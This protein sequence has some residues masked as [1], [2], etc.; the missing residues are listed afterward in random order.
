MGFDCT[1]HL[2]DEQ[3]IWN[4]FVPRLLGQS[5]KKT[6]LDR[7]HDNAA[8]LW[9]TARKALE[10][11]VNDEGEEIG[12][13]SVASLVCQLAC[14]YSACFLPHHYERGLAFSLWP[15]DLLEVELP[16]RFAHSPEPLF[17]EVVQ[18]YPRLKGKFPRWFT[19]NY[20]TGVYIPAEKVSAV[21][22]WLEEQLQTLSK[23]DRRTYRGLLAM[24]RAAEEKKLA[25]W[26]ATDLAIPVVGQVPG[27]PALFT[28]NYLRNTPGGVAPAEKFELP[29][30]ADWCCAVGETHVLSDSHPEATLVLDVSRWPPRCHTRRREFSWTGD[31]DGKGCWLLVSRIGAR[32]EVST[33]R[34]RVYTDLRK[35]PVR[36]VQAEQDGTGVMCRKG[37]LVGGRVVLV[38][39]PDN[40]E[41][42]AELTPWME[43]GEKMIPAPG[44][45][46]H[47]VRKGRIGNEE[48][49]SG[50]A[51]LADGREVLVWGK[52]GYEWDGRR[53]QHTFAHG[54]TNTYDDVSAVPAGADGLYFLKE[55]KLYEVHRGKKPSRHGPKWTNV[56]QVQPGP[57]GGL[58]LKEG[59]NPNDDVGKLYFPADRT[60][61]HIERELLGDQDLYDF[62]CYS[63]GASRIIASDGANLYAVPVETI[64][65]L[66]RFDARTDAEVKA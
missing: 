9:A 14:I 54:Q 52:E 28:A 64:L 6:P 65:A 53:F 50:V 21:R 62:L 1:F 58:L 15:D 57:E 7:V 22:V 49:V 45:P 18:Q 24:L 35:K 47:V 51:R 8:D 33:V 56:M 59:G 5:R 63:P 26:E 19:E 43:A 66:P 25:F 30:R 27:D 39:D 61:I 40:A 2:I 31:G 10:E 20:S 55:R 44:L 13:E 60:F 46:P 23:G 34:G 4:D 48:I 12:P 29:F 16:P 32:D 36:V 17:A 41:V 38:P 11:G 3:A 37:Y 42:G